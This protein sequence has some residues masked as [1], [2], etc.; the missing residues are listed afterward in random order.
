MFFTI[1]FILALLT[2]GL[3]YLQPKYI[4]RKIDNYCTNINF[5]VHNSKES[6]QVCITIDDAPYD[7]GSFRSI[8]D[9]LDKYENVKVTFFV[10]SCFVNG[11]NEKDL[12]RA[13]KSGHQ[14]ANHGSRDKVHALYNNKLLDKEVKECQD[15][16]SKLYEKADVEVPKD[17]YYR[18]GVGFINR[19]M[20]KLSEESKI[21]IFLGSVYPYD[22]HVPLS[23]VN[24][25]YVKWKL[26][27]NDIVIL[28]DRRWTVNALDKLLSDVYDKFN[29]VTLVKAYEKI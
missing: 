11:D 3:I 14:L 1:T 28:H 19:H 13:I 2:S 23:T 7:N 29:F 26:E 9:V 15:L 12:I 21:K 8:L 20:L 6:N 25:R 10:A 24:Y 27:P 4:L 22:P 16:I 18:P 5:F 17:V